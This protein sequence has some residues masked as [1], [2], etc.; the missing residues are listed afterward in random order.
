ML[1]ETLDFLSFT[2]PNV[3]Y[4]VIGSVIL[5]ASS[6]LVGSF[7]FLRKRALVGDAIAHSVLPGVAAAFMI[8]GVKDPLILIVGALI[9]GWLSIVMIDGIVRTTK[10]KSDAAIGIVLSVFFGVGIL[11]LTH[12]QQ[13]GNGAQS[14]LDSF[15]FGKAASL[16][17]DDIWVFSSIGSFLVVIIFLFFKAFKIVSFNPDYAQ[18][19]GLP[20]KF[21]EFLLSTI[22][23]LAVAVGIQ[24]VGVVLMAALLITPASGA[25]FWTNKLGKMLFIA[26]TFGV[27]SAFVGSYVSYI[28]PNMPTGPWV[29]MILSLLTV[30]SIWFAPKKGMLARLK[31]RRENQNKI[32]T[33]N[34]LKLFYHLG[35]KKEDFE[36]GRSQEI[37]LEN[38]DFTEVELKKGLLKLKKKNL[39]RNK[40]NLWYITQSG[41]SE[42]K[43]IIRLH[44][45][46]E[47]YLNQ[48]LK[49]EPDHVHN[50]AEAIEHIIT[51]D[52]EKQLEKELAYPEK[53]PHQSKIPYNDN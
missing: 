26:T 7:A 8:S 50:D 9:S 25:R 17:P 11:L 19:I 48:R 24:A 22:T 42:A 40:K 1:K 47:M 45:L 23:V 37:L 18:T 13:S 31:T 16:T 39:L 2:D 52:I 34:I 35:E 32:L 29:V 20:V 6:A 12:I 33:E 43:R 53:D 10:L 49:L 15:L 41:L 5:G 36:V 3:R 38:R 4:V 28:A 44:R 30:A 27:I 51:A 46:W 14:G 21:I